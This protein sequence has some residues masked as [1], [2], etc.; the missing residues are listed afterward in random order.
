MSA[1]LRLT[2][3]GTVTS[4]NAFQIGGLPFVS[5][6]NVKARAAA[7]V[8]NHSG[9]VIDTSGNK[10]GTLTG[11]LTHNA[12]E[13]TFAVIDLSDGSSEAVQYADVPD[14]L[15]IQISLAYITG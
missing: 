7:S 15:Y 5:T 1:S 2:D 14:D 8:Y 4:S 11:L 12:D 6:N 3:K 13:I 9:G 10:N